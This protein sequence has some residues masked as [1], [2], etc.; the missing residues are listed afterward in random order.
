MRDNNLC[1]NGGVQFRELL[2]RGLAW[3]PAQ[4]VCI[5][6]KLPEGQTQGFASLRAM[7]ITAKQTLCLQGCLSL[8]RI[9][10]S[11]FSG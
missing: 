3:P 7:F 11:C 5:A 1:S 8:N 4:I 10:H 6:A 9:G 2:T